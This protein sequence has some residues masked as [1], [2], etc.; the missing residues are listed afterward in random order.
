MIGGLRRDGGAT[1]RNWMGNLTCAPRDRVAP[2]TADELARVVR[3]AAAGGRRVRMA[4]TGHSWMPLVPTDD[5]LV[6]TR[7]LDRLVDVRGDTITVEA[8]MELRALLRH[9]A[10]AGLTVTG[11]SMLREVS[12]GGLVATGSHGTGMRYGALCD[13]VEAAELIDGRGERVSLRRADARLRAARIGLGAA[14]C[15]HTLT[16]RFPRRFNVAIVEELP[17]LDQAQR[18]MIRMARSHDFLSFYWGPTS[19]R[20][21]IYR[22][23]RTSARPDWSLRARLAERLRERACR[24]A[25]GAVVLSAMGE[26]PRITPAALR[27]GLDLVCVPHREVRT[28]AHALHP[29]RVFPKLWDSAWAVPLEAAEAAFATIRRRIGERAARGEYPV[30]IVVH[31]RFVKGGDALLSPTLGR[32]CAFIEMVTS[33]NAPGAQ[34]FYSDIGGE[35]MERFDALPHW[36]KK[37]HHLDRVRARY[38]ER[39]RRFDA[40]RRQLDPG[41]T[42]V[43]DFVE[44]L[45]PGEPVPVA[46]TP[47][48]RR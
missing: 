44:R 36:G 29:L 40:M 46:S 32:D 16:F 42:F 43:N 18:A 14:G 34:V 3:E 6:S 41:G 47:R 26:H 30:N 20:A 22:G 7:R 45:L 37:F 24:G 5:V 35:L 15:L 12:V 17:P 9:A 27:T 48:T 10:R 19:D 28:S 31:A 21:W 33:V 39:L 8:G 11:A 1:W 25:Y 2:R 13:H 4:G 23:D 38:G